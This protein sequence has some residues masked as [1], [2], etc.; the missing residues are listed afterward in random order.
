MSVTDWLSGV[1]GWLK[2]WQTGI[3]AILGFTIGTWINHRFNRR[4]DKW[5]RDQEERSII[6]AIYGEIISIRED[7]GKLAT[8]IAR[9][10]THGDKIFDEQFVKDHALPVP[11]IY[12]SLASKIG[13]VSSDLLIPI[14]K[15]YSNLRRTNASLPLLVERIIER[16]RLLA[17]GEL[18]LRQE[19]QAFHPIAVLRPAIATIDDI[20]P[21]LARIE[22]LAGM[23]P[24]EDPLTGLARFVLVEAERQFEEVNEEH[25][26]DGPPSAG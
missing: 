5:L 26:T 25:Q 19:R 22:K 16:E 1:L 15:F 2:G 3:G 6:V 4:R 8:A 10:E 12:P 7:I 9:I 24:V 20:K 13:L 17:G 14:T 11:I 23:P 21:A 18:K